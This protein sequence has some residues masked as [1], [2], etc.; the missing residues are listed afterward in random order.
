MCNEECCIVNLK[1]FFAANVSVS[2]MEGNTTIKLYC[3]FSAKFQYSVD[4]NEFQLCKD[5]ST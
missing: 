3:N 1:M 4:E 5:S 2:V